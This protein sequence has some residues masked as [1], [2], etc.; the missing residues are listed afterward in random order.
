[1]QPNV[2]AALMWAEG[3]ERRGMRL[4]RVRDTDTGQIYDSAALRQECKRLQALA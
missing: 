4:I 3:L 1:M 2:K